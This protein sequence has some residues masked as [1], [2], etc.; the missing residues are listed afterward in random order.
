MCAGT[1]RGLTLLSFALV[2]HTLAI[3]CCGSSVSSGLFVPNLLIGAAWGR[4]VSNTLNFLADYWQLDWMVC[5]CLCLCA[6]PPHPHPPLHPL[7]Y[8]LRTSMV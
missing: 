8:S 7:V 6:W 3:W 4:L 2:Y 1:F 5:L